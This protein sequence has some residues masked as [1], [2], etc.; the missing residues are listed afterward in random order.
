MTYNI[1][2]VFDTNRERTPQK[3][4]DEINENNCNLQRIENLYSFQFDLLDFQHA[5]EILSQVP[6]TS[7]VP[8]LKP[9]LKNVKGHFEE[10]SSLKDYF[11]KF[12][13]SDLR[14]KTM[15]DIGVGISSLFMNKSFIIDWRDISQIPQ[16]HFPKGKKG[17]KADF[18]GF[19]GDLRYYFEAKGRTSKNSINSAIANAKKQLGNIRYSGETKLAFVTY[20]SRDYL[21]FPSTLFVSD[22]PIED[23]IDLDINTVRMLHYQNILNYSG[24]LATSR[25]YSKLVSGIMKNKQTM[26]EKQSHSFSSMPIEKDLLKVLS[27]FEKESATMERR[28]INN[29]EFLGKSDQYLTQDDTYHFFRGVDYNIIKNAVALDFSFTQLKDEIVMKD[30]KA[31]IFSDGSILHITRESDNIKQKPIKVDNQQQELL[32]S[33]VLKNKLE[34]SYLSYCTSDNSDEQKEKERNFVYAYLTH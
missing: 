1:Q 16:D 9:Y 13:S 21:D 20:I 26:S 34:N 11:K 25:V 19:R 12:T 23:G 17:K 3:I 18:I 4:I 14:R 7:P 30:G 22:P 8:E 33:N 24:F 10:L 32:A 15:E 2:V 28:K 31:S 5:I 27:A 6:S 29:F